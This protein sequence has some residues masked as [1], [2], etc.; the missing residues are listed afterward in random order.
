V[1][2]ARRS[3][4]SF[5]SI[6]RVSLETRDRM[7]VRLGGSPVE[8]PDPDAFALSPAAPLVKVL[9]GGPSSVVLTGGPFDERERYT[10]TAPDGGKWPVMPDGI[11]D[12]YRP[13]APLGILRESGGYR[14][15]FFAPRVLG[16]TAELRHQPEDDPFAEISLVPDP[17]TGCWEGSTDQLAPGDLVAYKTT[18]APGGAEVDDLRFADPWSW[19]VVKQ[20]D[21]RRRSMSLILPDEL[22]QLPSADHVIVER[23]ARLIYEAHIKDVTRLHPAVPEDLRGSYP[24]AVYQEQGRDTF[25]DH[26]TRLGINTIE[27]L[28]LADYDYH[29]PPHGKRL[30][31]QHNTWNVYSRNHWGYMP[32]YWFAPE[33]RYAARPSIN[34][35]VGRDGAQ[36]RQLRE[37][38]RRQHELGFSVLVDVVYNHVAQYGENP[39]RQI[40]PLYSL[41]HDGKGNRISESGCGNDLASERPV[42][43]RLIVES[44]VHWTKMYGVDGFRFDLAGILDDGTLDAIGEALREHLPEVCLIAEPWGGRYDKTR[45]SVRGWSSWNDLYRDGIRG[46]DPMSDRGAL[47]GKKI[48]E[49]VR[50]ISGDLIADGGPFP[51]E[52]SGVKYLACHDGYTLADFQRIALRNVRGTTHAAE[53]SAALDHTLLSRMKLAFLILLSSRGMVMW[54]Q[55]DEFGHSKRIALDDAR[56]PHHGELDPDSYNKDN[57]TNWLEWPMANESTRK[58]LIEYVAGLSELRKKHPALTLA[59]RENL[60]PLPAN[61]KEAVGV[62]L[63]TGSDLLLLLFN[64][65][66]NREAVFRL[67]EGRWAAW[68]DHQVANAEHPVSG[69]FIGK[70][71]VPEMSGLLLTPIVR[72]L[73]QA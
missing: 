65:S 16:L 57:A 44:L 18:G 23:R 62:K 28:P 64:L 12:R 6:L 39:I 25:H 31:G 3:S 38:V 59:R 32:A 19:A 20:D 10:L 45:Y 13:D 41:R 36:V 70:A 56:D 27:W 11:L 17:E 4:T 7:L 52:E 67:P 51:H 24:G 53:E 58:E 71:V 21:W 5:P 68:A 55:G 33:G 50:H 63:S 2:S 8:L 35:W 72:E 60:I 30:P 61:H 47:F 1:T 49:L 42:I 46:F 9:R 34:G 26:L 40:D 69:A 48:G 15:R 43:R 22:I 66:G 73:E 54:H 37:M 29:E 14:F